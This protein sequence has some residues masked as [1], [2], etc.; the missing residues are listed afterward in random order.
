MVTKY[1]WSRGII[2]IAD[3][4]YEAYKRC[5]EAKPIVDSLN[6][7]TR[8]TVV[9]VP[10]IVN[11]TFALELYLKSFIIPYQIE[12]KKLGHNISKIYSKLEPK[13]QQQ[14]RN[15][16]EPKLKGW[17]QTFDE[18]IDGIGNGFEYWRYI[19]EKDDLGY[20]L[21]MSLNILPL[22]LDAVR[23]IIKSNQ[24]RTE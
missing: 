20:G 24:K 17:D 18:A 10:A 6:G 9:N 13:L 5:R 12:P 16:I 11:G 23:A 7:K 19:H 2:D 3:D 15:E 14:I 8:G 21:N 1:D 22:F 4:F